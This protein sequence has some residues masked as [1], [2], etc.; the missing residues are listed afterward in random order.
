MVA[1][2]DTALATTDT[3]GPGVPVVLSQWPVHQPVV[4]AASHRGHLP[5]FMMSGDVEI[6]RGDLFRLIFEGTAATPALSLRR[7]HHGGRWHVR[8]PVERRHGDLPSHRR[9]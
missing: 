3:S 8:V 9:R 1:V 6:L 4:L 2:E 5:S 7:T